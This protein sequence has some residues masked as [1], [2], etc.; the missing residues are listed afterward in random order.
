MADSWTPRAWQDLLDRRN[1]Q[2]SWGYRRNSDFAVEPTSL[3]VIAGSVI[4]LEASVRTELLTD[5]IEQIERAQQSDGSLGPA[6]NV[7][8]PGWPTPVVLWAWSLAGADARPRNRAR[9]WLLSRHGSTFNK[10]PGSPLGHDTTL[11]GWGWADDTHSWVEPTAMSLIALRRSG[12]KDHYRIARGLALLHDRAIAEGGWNY[13][14]NAVFGRSLRPKPGSTGLTLLALAGTTTETPA[15]SR[16]CEYLERTLPTIRSGMSLGLGI[17]GL[18]AWKRRPPTC[19]VWLQESWQRTRERNDAT[20]S[21]A[22]LLLAGA[23]V[24]VDELL[25]PPGDAREAASHG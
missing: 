23:A 8:K 7:P 13:G 19:D 11:P 22:W 9:A 4:P 20:I 2:A 10:P 12:V 18:A 15:I 16:A 17:L 25:F 24:S 1:S 6:A 5:P 14:N 3:A 21:L